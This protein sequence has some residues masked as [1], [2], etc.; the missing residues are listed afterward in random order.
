VRNSSLVKR[1]CADNVTGLKSPT[2]ARDAA[3]KCGVVGERSG[4]SEAVPVRRRGATRSENAG[5]SSVKH[6]RTMFA[7]RLR[8][9]TEGQSA[10]G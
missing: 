2:E 5:M 9:P 8:V 6:V 4:S 7:E 10:S 1:S 3:C